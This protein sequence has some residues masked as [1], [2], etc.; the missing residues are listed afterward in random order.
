MEEYT[1]PA[2]AFDKRDEIKAILAEHLQT[3]T[4]EKWLAVLEPADIWCSDVLNWSQLMEHEGFKALNMIQEVEMIDGYR[5]ETT[6]CPIRIDGE[7][8]VSSKGSPKL[9]QD[10]EKIINQFVTVKSNVDG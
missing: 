8:L 2:E 10:N 6:R 1:D 7:L 3:G 4:T 5:Y 9:G